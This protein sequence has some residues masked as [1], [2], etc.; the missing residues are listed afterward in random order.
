MVRKNIECA[1]EDGLCMI[2][3]VGD[4]LENDECCKYDSQHTEE[5]C[6]GFQCS[7]QCRLCPTTCE[8]LAK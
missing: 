1:G 3:A 7:E 6:T 2:C 8:F 5:G 4:D